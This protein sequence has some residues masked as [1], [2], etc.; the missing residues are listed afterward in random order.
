VTATAARP[1]PGQHVPVMLAEMLAAFAPIPGRIIADATFGGGGYTAALLEAG[2]AKVFA[3]D[4][5]PDALAQGAALVTRFAPRLALLHGSFGD[6][7]ELLGAGGVSAV[8]G[9]VFDLG[10]SSLQLDRPERGFSF[11]ADGPLDMRMDRSRGATAAD[12]INTLPEGDL[13]AILKD[14][15]EERAARR[16]ARAIVTARRSA[17]VTRTGELAALCRGILGPRPGEGIDPATRTF[18]ALRIA[19]NDEL[20][21]LERGLSAAERVLRPGGRLVVVAFHSLE[22]RR[23]KTFLKMRSGETTRPS[24]HRPAA[25]PAPPPSFRL[26]TRRALKASEE[27]VRRNPRARSARLRAAERTEAPSWPGVTTQRRQAA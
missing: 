4:R 24:R 12:L 27:E 26:I 9:V 5:D 8:D 15:G 6:L 18:Q 17:P 1:E 13:A 23:V 21:E 2:A 11:R 22:D 19:V 7:V 20:G 14:F 10:V 16:I 25:T 3:I